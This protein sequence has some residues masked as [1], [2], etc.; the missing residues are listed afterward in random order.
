M[1]HYLISGGM[2]GVL[3][4]YLET[5]QISLG[6]ISHTYDLT[7]CHASQLTL[8]NNYRQE[9]LAY[10]SPLDE[11]HAYFW[12]REK[13]SSQAEVDF[14][15]TVGSKIIP[16]EVKAGSTGQLKSLQLLMEEKK[17]PIGIRVSQNPLYFDGR[18]LSVPLYMV[19]EI[20]RLI[21]LLL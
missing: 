14:I 16:I 7:A 18:I 3:Q 1:R 2:P 11:S 9:L 17:M 8:L 15:I 19:G 6:S 12:C 5:K 21:N 13:K 20:P 4:T 10:S